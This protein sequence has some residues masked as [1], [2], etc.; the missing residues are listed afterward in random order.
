MAVP[1]RCAQLGKYLG[2]VVAALAGDDDLAALERVDIERV[3][4]RGFVLGL[5][6]GLATGVAGGE[7]QGFDQAEVAFCLHAIHQHRADHAAPAHQA[8]Q[9]AQFNALS[10]E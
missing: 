10:S 6:R 1:A 5:R 7:E 9:L 3:L 4:Q 2:G 8:Y